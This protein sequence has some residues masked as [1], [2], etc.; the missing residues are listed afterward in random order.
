MND[1]KQLKC[2]FRV[3]NFILLAT[4]LT[5]WHNSKLTFPI[6]VIKPFIA[7]SWLII[8]FFHDHLNTWNYERATSVL[9][10]LWDTDTCKL[11]CF[12]MLIISSGLRYFLNGFWTVKVT[13]CISIEVYLISKWDNILIRFFFVFSQVRVKLW[14][15]LQ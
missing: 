11:N 10:I 8:V 6:G 14:C 15:L 9:E 12:K 1:M 13:W 5:Q 4:S 3:S 2:S 7:V